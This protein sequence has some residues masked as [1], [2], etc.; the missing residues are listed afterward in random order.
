[1]NNHGEVVHGDKN[2]IESRIEKLELQVKET[3][4]LARLEVAKAKI[5]W[6]YADP[7]HKK[8]SIS[9]GPMPEG[10]H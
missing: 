1:M 9:D 2:S 8:G 10:I 6:A 5:Y 3:E 4:L 7:R